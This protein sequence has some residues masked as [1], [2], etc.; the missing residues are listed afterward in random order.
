MRGV[1]RTVALVLVALLAT[2]GAADAKTPG[3]HGGKPTG[4]PLRIHTIP[5]VPGAR[6]QTDHKSYYADGKGVVVLPAS[7]VKRATLVS[8]LR[9]RV[10][11]YDKRLGPTA[12]A[13][14]DRWFGRNTVAFNVFYRMSFTFRDLK[15]QPVDPST[16]SSFMVKSRTGVRHQLK[17]GEPAWL[18]GSRVVPF[19]GILVS[20]DI[21][22]QTES[23]LVDGNDVV[24]RAQQRFTPRKTRDFSIRLLFYSI[25]ATSKDA[26]FGFSTGS[27]IQIIY[28]SGRIATHALHG[29]QVRV[30]GLPRGNYK[31][32]VK[33]PG[34]SFTRPVSVSRN[35]E[36]ELKVISWV[37]MLFT[38]LVLTGIAGGLLVARRPQLRAKLR[39]RK[40][41]ARA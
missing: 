12:L 4:G 37:D 30:T 10:K 7:V 26:I 2:A 8:E 13:Q 5:P 36:V 35:Q 22:Y 17:P 23:A 19:Q 34:V 14:F 9:D 18:Q 38:F 31:V 21:D 11:V 15:G 28:P 25:H 1:G 16:V 41:L 20:K 33:A 39:R 6:F 3:K 27:A 32:K 40:A 29:G 24:N